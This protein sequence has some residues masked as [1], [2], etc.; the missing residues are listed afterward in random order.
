MSKSK[1]AVVSNIGYI[2]DAKALITR[3]LTNTF[4]GHTEW[5]RDAAERLLAYDPPASYVHDVRWE[6]GDRL[7]VTYRTNPRGRLLTFVIPKWE[8]P[9]G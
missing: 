2:A 7:V 5:A 8:D 3:Q 9:H 6:P 4:G 1:T